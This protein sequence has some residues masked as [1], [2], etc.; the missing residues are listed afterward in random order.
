MRKIPTLSIKVLHMWLAFLLLIV[1]IAGIIFRLNNL[2]SKP[3]WIDE[4]YTLLR[5]SAY[6]SREATERLY[7]GN[8]VKADK[9]LEYQKVSSE[10]NFAGTIE[11]LAD[12]EPQHPPLYFLLTKLWGQIAGSSKA[13]MRIL[14]ALCSLL[15]FPA[16]YWLCIELFSFPLTNYM[17]MALCA[18]SPIYLRYAQEVR[19]YSLWLVFITLSS[20]SLLKA[21]KKSSPKIWTIYTIFVTFSIYCQPITLFTVLGHFI[22]LLLAEKSRLKQKLIAYF[23][24]IF[25]SLILF[26]PWLWI[27]LSKLGVIKQTTWSMTNSLPFSSLVKLWGISISH[28]FLALHFRYEIVL[29]YFAPIVLSL[30]LYAFYFLYRHNHKAW[31]FITSLTGATFIPF[32]VWDLVEGGKRS[33]NERFFLPTYLG[34]YLVTSYLLAFKT[35]D[36][37]QSLLLKIFWQTI[38]TLILVLGIFICG[39]GSIANTWWGWSEFELS[40][41]NIVNKSEK[42]LVITDRRLYEIMSFT[43]Q[44]NPAT[45]MILLN[46]YKEINIPSSFDNIFLYNPS[47]RL[48]SKIEELNYTLETADEFE[49]NITSTKIFLYKIK[50]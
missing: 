23:C 34:I 18:I 13:A 12:E 2:T 48:L 9:V 46:E 27:I 31:V 16:V 26:L 25:I 45:D 10:K 5:A 47:K 15:L 42:P 40:F 20:A 38:T 1:I 37:K 4:T 29:L 19:Q 3:Y 49:D 41:S 7:N 50:K 22:Y 17:A 33:A 8:I 43:H 24:S 6:S 39:F 21:L 35:T 14:P 30:F 36:K 32:W 44:L 28:T 11:G